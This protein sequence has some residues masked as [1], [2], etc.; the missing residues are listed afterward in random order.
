MV[1]TCVKLHKILTGL[2][3]RG[4]G[5]RNVGMPGIMPSYNKQHFTVKTADNSITPEMVSQKNRQ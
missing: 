1:M 2:V 3:R 5:Q 4:V